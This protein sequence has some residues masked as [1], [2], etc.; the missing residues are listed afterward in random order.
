M[1]GRLLWRPTL[2]PREQFALRFRVVTLGPAPTPRPLRGAHPVWG[3]WRPPDTIK[4][5]VGMTG[6]LSCEPRDYLTS[7]EIGRDNRL[8]IEGGESAHSN[9]LGRVGALAAEP[10][11]SV[12]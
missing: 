7:V 8:R 10:I 11:T 4:R 9:T 5:P 12:S 2:A 3:W 1:I 6:R